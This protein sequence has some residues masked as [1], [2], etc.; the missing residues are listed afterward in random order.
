MNVQDV[1]ER[2]VRLEENGDMLVAI[3]RKQQK[4][5]EKYHHI[6]KEYR[7]TNDCPVN[8]HD[9]K[10]QLLIKD[11]AWRIT[12][13]L[14]EAFD[15]LKEEIWAKIDS[16][17]PEP[18]EIQYE[19]L[20]NRMVHAQEEIADA[21]HFLVEMSILSN[22]QPGDIVG[23]IEGDGLD[24]LFSLYNQK[25]LRRRNP[26]LVWADFQVSLGMVCHTLKNKPWKQ[27]QMMTDI[28]EYRGRLIETFRLF[29]PIAMSFEMNAEQL[30]SLYFRKNKVNQFRQRSNY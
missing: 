29:I 5:M 10:G 23:S 24:F 15:A 26:A 14:S 16:G 9:A 11:F 20:S 22:I 12:E 17:P 30:Y 18:G 6:E 19:E 13:E 4:L 27:T 8:L 7:L 1:N 2:E 25:H 3:F 21:L 28:K